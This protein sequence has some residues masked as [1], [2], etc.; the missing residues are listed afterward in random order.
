[1]TSYAHF[2]AH[3]RGCL[4]PLLDAE[5]ARWLWQHLRRAFPE[6]LGVTLMPDHPHIVAPDEPGGHLR[7][8]NVLGAFARRF[9]LG[10]LWATFPEPVRLTTPDK[11][12]RVLRYAL[13]NP[14]RP[15]RHAGRVVQLVRDPLAWP[16]STLRDVVG[17][18]VDPWVTS[19]RLPSALAWER[20]GFI[21]SFHRYVSADPHVDVAGTP[22]PRIA[23]STAMPS[24]S[25]DD[26]VRA[27]LAATRSPPSALCHKSPARMVL[28]GLA[29]RQGW[30]YP[31]YIAKLC[32]T[33]PDTIARLARRCPAAWLEAA[34]LCLGDT[35]L[36]A[37]GPNVGGTDVGWPQKLLRGGNVGGTDVPRRQIH[38]GYDDAK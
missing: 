24:G 27:A 31:R 9:D 10:E 11:V 25:F 34:A 22:L 7:L 38:E 20:D 18:I 30:R 21:A 14:C 4:V 23:P 16:W 17:A 29:Y 12:A 37:P 33:H 8:A 35:R 32:G 2:V 13:L 19:G 26:I 28:A 5:R 3:A 6:A 15:W 1:M 36:I